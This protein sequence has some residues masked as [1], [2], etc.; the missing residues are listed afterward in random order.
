MSLLDAFK[1]KKPLS[2]P[3][4]TEIDL[5]RLTSSQEEMDIKTLDQ[6]LDHIAKQS[7]TIQGLEH[8]IKEKD[9]SIQFLK[10]DL[11]AA[12][13]KFGLVRMPSE[14]GGSTWES[15]QVKELSSS[16]AELT[17]VRDDILSKLGKAETKIAELEANK[18]T[19]EIRAMEFLAAQGGKPLPVSGS[20]KPQ[21]SSKAQVMDA[22]DEARRAGDQ[23]AVKRY[24]A[25]YQKLKNS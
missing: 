16:V 4:E 3:S 10:A 7:A 25:E 24:Y 20:G 12:I 9:T 11:E 17:A 6:S 22:M 23:E 18:R 1:R 2:S 13:E 5:E 8:E 19:V 15:S 21:P 14:R